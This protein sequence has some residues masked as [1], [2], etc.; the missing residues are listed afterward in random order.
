MLG[1]LPH[2]TRHI[3]RA[4]LDS[5]WPVRTAKIWSECRKVVLCN[6]H[7]LLARKLCLHNRRNV[8]HSHSLMQTTLVL[9]QASCRLGGLFFSGSSWAWILF[10]PCQLPTCQMLSQ[11]S[12]QSA[13]CRPMM[14][15][16]WRTSLW[17]AWW[18]AVTR[19]LTCES[20]T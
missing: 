3:Q 5:E 19:P 8:E 13:G 16:W 11:L 17:Q 1:R 20:Q 6:S 14:K 7:S 15:R 18:T 4:S 12:G 10:K 2:P 9:L